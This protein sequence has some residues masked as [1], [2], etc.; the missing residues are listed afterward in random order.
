VMFDEDCM[1]TG[2]AL[3]AAMALQHLAG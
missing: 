3:Y 1:T 2:I